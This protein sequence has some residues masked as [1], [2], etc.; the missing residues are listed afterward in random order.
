MTLCERIRTRNEGER[1]QRAQR[2]TNGNIHAANEGMSSSNLDLKFLPPRLE[3]HG[4]NFMTFHARIECRTNAFLA[5]LSRIERKSGK[6]R[7]KIPERGCS[8]SCMPIEF[9]NDTSVTSLTTTSAA[10]F[11][12]YSWDSRFIMRARRYQNLRK[13]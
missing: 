2:D 11:P 1:R 9:F 7:M 6:I 4:R 5:S 12:C 3:A 8:R 10:N 13:A